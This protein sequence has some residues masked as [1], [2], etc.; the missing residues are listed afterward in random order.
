MS[1]NENLYLTFVELYNEDELNSNM[2]LTV[3]RN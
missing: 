1:D 2:N 3:I